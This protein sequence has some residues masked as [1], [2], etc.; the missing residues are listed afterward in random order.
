M[1]ATKVEDEEITDQ[2]KRDIA[3]FMRT[4]ERIL[5]SGDKSSMD[6]N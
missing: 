5:N 4:R 1:E 6:S 2:M 3:D